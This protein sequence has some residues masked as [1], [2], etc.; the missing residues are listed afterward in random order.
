MMRLANGI[1]LVVNAVLALLLLAFLGTRGLAHT[2]QPFSRNGYM[3][4]S[5]WKLFRRP[6][7]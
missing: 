5:I 7:D 3:P 6:T 1:M 2:D 4:K